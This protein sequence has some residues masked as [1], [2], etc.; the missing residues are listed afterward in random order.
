MPKRP[1]SHRLEDQSRIVFSALL[2]E[3]WVESPRIKDYGIDSDVD[4]FAG[5]D[6]TG[7][8]F[9]VQLKASDSERA[10]AV[11]I[12]G[13]TLNYWLSQDVPVLLVF[14]RAGDS[15]VWF[16]WAH[17]I[18]PAP[19]EQGRSSVRVRFE[20][21][22]LWR[23]DTPDV[24][25][26]EV[27][28]FRNIRN[29]RLKLPVGAVVIGS[30]AVGHIA[31]GDLVRVLRNAMRRDRD[32]FDIQPRGG[33]A[34]ID[35]RILGN[36]VR[37][38]LR[39]A[40]PMYLHYDAAP[41]LQSST[42]SMN[43]VDAF[44]S[45]ALFAVALQL[46]RVGF[47]KE[48]AV[49]A[50]RAS[51]SSSMMWGSALDS[52]LRVLIDGGNRPAAIK[53]LEISR[54]TRENVSL[55]DLMAAM[56][57]R[58]RNQAEDD[59]VVDLLL[60]WAEQAVAEGE[61]DKA[62]PLFYNTAQRL[63]GNDPERAVILL[64]RAAEIDVAYKDRPYWRSD[65][66]GAQFLAGRYEES[67]RLYLKAVSSGDDSV[68][69]RC[70][71]ALMFAGSYEQALPFL[72]EADEQPEHAEY[73]IKS[74]YLTRLIKDLRIKSQDRDPFKAEMLCAESRPSRE[75]AISALQED[76]LFPVAL[77]EVAHSSGAEGEVDIDYL[78]A[79]TFSAPENADAWFAVL[80]SAS[81]IE[82]EVLQ[83]DVLY[84]A[85]RFAGEELLDL[86]WDEAPGVAGILQEAF[87]MLPVEDFGPRVTRA[88]T[89]GSLEYVE[90]TTDD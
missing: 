46:N 2:P 1:R 30:G 45:D 74:R 65:M 52:A 88:V 32:V 27:Q 17:L 59:P 13:E 7:S 18:D 25:E 84:C 21:A 36:E 24:I 23:E 51:A 48:A 62:A 54:E 5:D 31:A 4:I 79:A 8:R 39:G 35:I 77:W 15:K 55:V 86:A 83:L 26:S 85:R 41:P 22:D 12:R 44:A 60:S 66:A 38:G 11:S 10:P 58:P 90:I 68:R 69:L 72:L 75:I 64:Q 49:I 76:M 37:V 19:L 80:R 78:L 57:E 33:P 87:T 28:A 63:V 14:W 20:D 34:L 56:L 73:R 16:R 61:P 29:R 81:A 3:T 67:S 71:D 70:G 43:R 9:S 82:D 6:A 47:L 50:E 89:Y 40:S 53:L 42:E